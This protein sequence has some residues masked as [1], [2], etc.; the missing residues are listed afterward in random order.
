MLELVEDL[1]LRRAHQVRPRPR[2]RLHLV[3]VSAQH[4]PRGQQYVIDQPAPHRS[5]GHIGDVCCVADR[6]AANLS[7]QPVADRLIPRAQPPHGTYRLAQAAVSVWIKFV[8]RR[9]ESGCT[10]RTDGVWQGGHAEPPQSGRGLGRG[11]GRR[12]PAGLDPHT[13]RERGRYAGRSR[14]RGEL[15]ATTTSRAARAGVVSVSV[16]FT[17]VRRRPP[18][19]IIKR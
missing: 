1:L 19:G 10:V 3:A 15:I 18:N 16:S 6:A 14:D 4:Q 5:T 9:H 13:C 2:R 17:P 11:R 7:E 12:C 8:G